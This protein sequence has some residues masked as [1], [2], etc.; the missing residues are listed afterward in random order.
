MNTEETKLSGIEV[1]FY[2]QNVT[3]TRN[4]SWVLSL[5]TESRQR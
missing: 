1:T 4:R 3:G 2:A 5:H